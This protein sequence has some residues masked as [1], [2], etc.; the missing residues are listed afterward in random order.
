MYF[1]SRS[2]GY[3]TACV[4]K[5]KTTTWH[6]LSCLYS[7]VK[8]WE[9]F[10]ERRSRNIRIRIYDLLKFIGSFTIF[11]HLQINIVSYSIVLLCYTSTTEPSTK[12]SKMEELLKLLPNVRALNIHTRIA[13]H[14]G[15]RTLIETVYEH[16]TCIT[17]NNLKFHWHYIST[18]FSHVP[19]I[20]STILSPRSPNEIIKCIPKICLWLLFEYF[21]EPLYTHRKIQFIHLYCYQV[22]YLIQLWSSTVVVFQSTSRYSPSNLLCKLLEFFPSLTDPRSILT[23]RFESRNVTKHRA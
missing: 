14:E 20:L 5:Y 6:I 17:W 3:K 13:F 12:E 11:D 22:A 8:R 2:W 21:H 23:E 7:N 15:S 4:D 9:I 10:Y 18:L 19:D 16:I 1:L